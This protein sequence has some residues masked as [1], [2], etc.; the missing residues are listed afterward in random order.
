VAAYDGHGTTSTKSGAVPIT[1]S[2]VLHG[3]GDNNRPRVLET[4]TFQPTHSGYDQCT[5]AA[6]AE[7]LV[8]HR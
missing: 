5:E 3:K 6:M 7:S 2:P 1:A 8:L 4:T